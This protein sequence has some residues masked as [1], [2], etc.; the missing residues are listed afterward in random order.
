MIV[1]FGDSVAEDIY[2][3][4]RTRRVRRIQPFLLK[5]I[6]RKLDILDHADKLQDLSSPPGNRLE[7]LKG[8][9]EGCHSIRVNDQWRLVFRWQDGNAYDVSF[10][11]YH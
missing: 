1:S 8:D 7:A 3:G 10:T 2:H 6:E 4:N 5:A 11:D 9:M